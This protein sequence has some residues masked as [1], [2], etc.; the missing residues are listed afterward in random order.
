MELDHMAARL[1]TVL[2]SDV[3]IFGHAP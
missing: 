2:G 3:D 1:G